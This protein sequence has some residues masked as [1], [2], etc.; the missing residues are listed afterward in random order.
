MPPDGTQGRRARCPKCGAIVT[1]PAPVENTDEYDLAPAESSITAPPANAARPSPRSPPAHGQSHPLTSPLL[2]SPPAA[3][4]TSPL[5]A[6][7]PV[8]VSKS[9]IRRFTYVLLL[10]ALIPLRTTFFPQEDHGEELALAIVNHPELVQRAENGDFTVSQVQDR[11]V[12]HPPQPPR[13][14]A[15]PR[16]MSPM[17]TGFWLPSPPPPLSRSSCSS[18]PRPRSTPRASFSPASSP[19]PPASFCCSSSNSPPST[20]P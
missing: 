8:A 3:R 7:Y 15:L 2:S 20:C 1:V 18:S 14:G 17:P 10:L 4:P 13:D 16:S 5:L 12:Q 11:V 6:S 19:A 9:S